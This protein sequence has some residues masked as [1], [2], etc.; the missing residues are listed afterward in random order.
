V[1]LAVGETGL[2]R[3]LADLGHPARGLELTGSR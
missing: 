3:R 2:R 1:W